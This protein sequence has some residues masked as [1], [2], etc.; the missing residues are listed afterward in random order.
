MQ[1][2]EEDTKVE[3]VMKKFKNQNKVVDTIVVLQEKKKVMG[4]VIN[5][6]G[7]MRRLTG[8]REEDP[9][10]NAMAVSMLYPYLGRP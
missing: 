2:P 1:I 10:V 9:D 6:Q 4:G 7:Y 5:G 3:D 8:S